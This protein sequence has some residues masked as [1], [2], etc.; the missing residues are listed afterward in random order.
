MSQR[1]QQV[2]FDQKPE[3]FYI[4]SAG[5]LTYSFEPK[6]CRGEAFISIAGFARSDWASDSN[7]MMLETEENSR[8]SAGLSSSDTWT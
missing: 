3:L 1:L 4:R 5:S 2:R 7:S 8:V 6:E